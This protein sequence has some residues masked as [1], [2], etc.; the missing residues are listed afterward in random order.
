MKAF[1]FLVVVDIIPIIC[2][3]LHNLLNIINVNISM[4]FKWVLW[5]LFLSRNISDILHVCVPGMTQHLRFS[6]WTTIT[7]QTGEERMIFFFF[8]LQ[9][10]LVW[11]VYFST[12][13]P[14]SVC[15]LAYL[16]V[17]LSACL[18]VCL[19][20]FTLILN[21]WEPT[22]KILKHLNRFLGHCPPP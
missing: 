1:S 5:V 13:F 8:F 15:L 11:L 12:R 22:V 21:V 14:V 2:Q 3:V 20:I 19:P 4:N 7:T 17:F 16:S 10:K 18:S 6:T 9:T